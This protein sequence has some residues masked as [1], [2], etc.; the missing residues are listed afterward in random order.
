MKKLGNLEYKN[1]NLYNSIKLYLKSFELNKTDSTPLSN[2]A[3]AYIE[4]KLYNKA[5]NISYKALDVIK[6]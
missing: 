3:A 1:D 4:L 5:I 6:L 2:V